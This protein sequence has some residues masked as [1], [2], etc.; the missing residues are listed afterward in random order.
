MTLICFDRELES[1]DY[2]STRNSV[3][4]EVVHDKKSD[5]LC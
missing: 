1:A 5:L 4:A 3:V 2:S